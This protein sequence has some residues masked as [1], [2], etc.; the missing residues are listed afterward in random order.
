MDHNVDKLCAMGHL[1][2]LV[3]GLKD[4]KVIVVNKDFGVT[5]DLMG[6]EVLLVLMENLDQRDVKEIMVLLHAVKSGLMIIHC[7]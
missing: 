2:T 5:V 7:R 4:K 1:V 6:L 3:Q